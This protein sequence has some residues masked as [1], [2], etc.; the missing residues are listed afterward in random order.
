[1]NFIE[2]GQSNSEQI[3]MLHGGGLSWWNFRKEA[4]LLG[5]KYHVILPII[6][7]HAGS[8][9][10]FVSIEECARKLVE[11]IEENF[12][13]RIKALCGLSLGA[14]IAVEMLAQA[15]NICQYAV[16][17]SVSLIPSKMTEKLV[18]PTFSMSYGLISK[19]WFAKLQF[20]SL[21]MRENLYEDYFRDTREIKKEDM[22][23]FLEA[24]TRYALKASVKKSEA[25]VLVIVGG[26]EQ[27]N[28]IKSAKQL[29]QSIKGARLEIKKGLYHGEFSI[30]YPEEYVEELI[31][32][33]EG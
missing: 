11:Y 12:G 31:G 17:E 28:M 26:K 24:N 33:I 27:S 15:A 21:H 32:F 9:S 8:D 16:I 10:G 5:E 20:K 1:M 19:E 4:E 2:Y 30:N 3:M 14:Q 13:G 23:A 6:D 25:G 7:G 22:I 29:S 18:G